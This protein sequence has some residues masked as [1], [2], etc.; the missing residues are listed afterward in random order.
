MK[1]LLKALLIIIIVLI[2]III[3]KLNI[4]TNNI[5]NYNYIPKISNDKDKSNKIND[6]FNDMFNKASPWMLSRN[7]GLTNRRNKLL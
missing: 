4:L 1:Y 3:L 7:I 6:N 5:I 2:I